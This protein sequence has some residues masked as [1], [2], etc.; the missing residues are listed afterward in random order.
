MTRLT[1]MAAAPIFAGLEA[2]T[3][4]RIAA[5]G[6]H[7]V[8]EPGAAL[9]HEGD[10][11]DG[12]Y[13]VETGLIRVWRTDRDGNPFTLAFLRPGASLGEMALETAPRSA[14]ATAQQIARLFHLPRA[15]FEGL[16]GTEPAFARRM[17]EV[18][19]ARV[20]H[21]NGELH[22]LAYHSLR[23]RLARK[24]LALCGSEGDTPP[25]LSQR[26]IA[27]MLG[28][29]REAVNKHLRALEKDGALALEQ[30]RARILDMGRLRKYLPEV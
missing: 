25:P 2:G 10:P 14:N 6:R 21:L 3:I 18:L 20:R 8:L 28:V 15:S 12:L 5:A 29:T 1:P 16:I 27:A 26:E 7:E 30:G 17:I 23:A 19:A 4:S 9:F 22:A 24:L 11:S 13:V